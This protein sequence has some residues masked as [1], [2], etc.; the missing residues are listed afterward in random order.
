MSPI[1]DRPHRRLVF[2]FPEEQ[3]EALEGDLNTKL[4]NT[5]R[6]SEDLDDETRN[7]LIALIRAI[8]EESSSL[9][10]VQISLESWRDIHEHPQHRLK[11]LNKRRIMPSVMNPD[12]AWFWTR[13]WQRM[14][15]EA[16]ADLAAGRYRDFESMDDFLADLESGNE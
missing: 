2:D 16:E 14:E 12:Q 13:K 1:K 8:A 11:M 4:P 3:W 15:R 6:V 10:G 7:V 5:I 9:S